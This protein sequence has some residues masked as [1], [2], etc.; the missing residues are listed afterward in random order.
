MERLEFD[1]LPKAD[2]ERIETVAKTMFENH[3]HAELCKPE[4]IVFTEEHLE[5]ILD[6]G[7]RQ[8]CHHLL[9]KVYDTIK[10]GDEEHMKWLKD[11]CEELKKDL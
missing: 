6:A 11:K 9:D 8:Y 2:Q 7:I 1:D 10:H 3:T 4:Q 5:K